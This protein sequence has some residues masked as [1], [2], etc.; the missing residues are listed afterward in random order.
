L[1]RSISG[2]HFSFSIF[3]FSFRIRAEHVKMIQLLLW[4]P[5]QQHKFRLGIFV[6]EWN[7]SAKAN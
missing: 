2:S 3:F 6:G 4:L 7:R 1:W 5:T